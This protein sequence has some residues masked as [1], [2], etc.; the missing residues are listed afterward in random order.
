MGEACELIILVL[1]LNGGR[2]PGQTKYQGG[3]L[4]ESIHSSERSD[5]IV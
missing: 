4:G 2:N 5:L 3:R 1:R